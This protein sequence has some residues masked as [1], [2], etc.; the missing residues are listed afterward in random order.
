MLQNTQTYFRNTNTFTQLIKET[1]Q[2]SG[3]GLVEMREPCL[4]SKTGFL[5]ETK[6]CTKKEH[7]GFLR[8]HLNKKM[9]QD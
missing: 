5:F 3:F 1:V 6:L 7:T 8:Q 9:P 4:R 2:R